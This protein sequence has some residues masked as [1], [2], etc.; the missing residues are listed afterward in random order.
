M[1][2]RNRIIDVLGTLA[3]FSGKITGATPGTWATNN[4]TKQYF[5]TGGGLTEGKV[6][7]DVSYASF[8]SLASNTRLNY[9]VTVQGSNS[10]TFATPIANLAVINLGPMQPDTC[11]G[12]V[13]SSV[14]LT[15]STTRNLASVPQRFVVPFVNQV[16]FTNY[17]YLRA[18]CRSVG[19]VVTGITFKA[20]VT[21]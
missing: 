9:Q 7:L 10:A 11:A 14:G 19:T 8:A 15:P 2:S 3:S 4:G 18:W 13:L 6:I 5:D 17:R 20:W 16:K 12:A 1:D 21:K